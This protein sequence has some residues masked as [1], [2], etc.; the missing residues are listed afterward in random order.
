MR[1]QVTAGLL[2]LPK[3]EGNHRKKVTKMK[4]LCLLIILPLLQ[5]VSVSFPAPSPGARRTGWAR[6]GGVDLG[7]ALG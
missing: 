6:C 7:F 1:F 5:G 3:K 2:N 4:A